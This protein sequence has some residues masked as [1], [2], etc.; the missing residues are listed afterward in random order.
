[1]PMMAIIARRPLASSELSFFFLGWK[2]VSVELVGLPVLFVV[3]ST[4]H[5]VMAMPLQ[6]HRTMKAILLMAMLAGAEVHQ[7]YQGTYSGDA[8]E[9]VDVSKVAKELMAAMTA[10]PQFEEQKGDARIQGQAKRVAEQIEALMALPKVQEQVRRVAKQM[11]ALMAAPNV[12]EQVGVFLEKVSA[13]RPETKLTEPVYALDETMKVLEADEHVQDQVQ[14]VA[15]QLMVLLADPSFQKQCKHIVERIEEM[16]ADRNLQ[17]QAAEFSAPSEAM[18]SESPQAASPL[19]GLVGRRFKAS[20]LGHAGLEA[21]TFGKSSSLAIRP[22]MGAKSLVVPPST[23]AASLRPPAAFP[24]S[25]S[26]VRA[27]VRTQ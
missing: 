26:N 22:G 15:R 18:A 1:M 12:Q 8:A 7:H 25:S 17:E 6:V 3:H 9:Q 13:M 20:S 21:T 4:H 19:E 11:D 23:R 10:E 2:Q 5:S 27:L 14:H 16:V 24:G